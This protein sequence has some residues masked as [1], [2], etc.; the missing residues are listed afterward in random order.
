MGQKRL[1]GQWNMQRRLGLICLGFLSAIA[2]LVSHPQM[3]PSALSQSASPI[4]S[5]P[6][7]LR[8][9]P[10]TPG[11]TPT[12]LPTNNPTQP[13][14]NPTDSPSPFP[15]VSPGSPP[16]PLA[17]PAS[18][19]P[20]SPLQGT[21]RDPAGR[22]QV[23]LLPGFKATPLAGSVLVEAPDGQLAYSI[24]VQ[25][26]PATAPIG[27]RPEVDEAEALARVA[28]TVFQ[29]GE[30]FQPGFPRS[31]AGGGI[32]MDWTGSLTIAGQTQPVGGTI[33]VRPTVKSILLL[34]VAAT[35]TGSGQVAS[36]TAALA[37]SLQAL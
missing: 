35:Q 16:R 15:V 25:A 18:T 28:T 20:P 31:E 21:Y 8:A 14:V 5:P 12:Q 7:S 9:T 29:R 6:P 10:T 3:A 4:A 17:P 23:G 19:A 2:I 24:V 30:G 26:Q 13:S 1:S 11:V 34:L 32:V 36:A 27:L 22:F 37:N 33:L